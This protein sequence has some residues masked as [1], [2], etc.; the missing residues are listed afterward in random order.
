M[1]LC[2]GRPSPS[3][4]LGGRR[5]GTG[6]KLPCDSSNSTNPIMSPHPHDPISSY[7]PPKGCISSWHPMVGEGVFQHR[8]LRKTQALSPL[9]PPVTVHPVPHILTQ[10][11]VTGLVPPVGEAMASGPPSLPMQ[12]SLSNGVSSPESQH[13]P[14]P[15]TGTDD[16]CL[17]CACKFLRV[18]LGDQLHTELC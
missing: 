11:L 2:C 8:S 13:W 10:P 14:L 6:S 5:A 17:G 4:V 18:P 12:G 9:P 16:R 1:V 3:C 15:C 7:L